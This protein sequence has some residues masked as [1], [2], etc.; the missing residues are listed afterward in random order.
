MGHMLPCLAQLTI[1][2]AVDRAYSTPFLGCSREAWLDPTLA[3][4]KAW[5]GFTVGVEAEA[6]AEREEEGAERDARVDDKARAEEGATATAERRSG[7]KPA[8]VKSRVE[9]VNH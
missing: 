5:E 9:L 6:E 3:K 2:S 7:D 1:L 4:S 8:Q